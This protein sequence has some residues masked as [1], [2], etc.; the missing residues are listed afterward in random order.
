MDDP[1]IE[2]LLLPAEGGKQCPSMVTSEQTTPTDDIRSVDLKANG[3]IR[4]DNPWFT[5]P[6]LY[7]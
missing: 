4:T 1:K 7:R 6:E 2:S 3:R 5:K